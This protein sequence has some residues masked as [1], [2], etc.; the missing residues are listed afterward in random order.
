MRWRPAVTEATV[1]A[2]RDGR[3]PSP[4]I[5][6]EEIIWDF[7]SELLATRRVSD[8]TYDRAKAQFGE[9]GVVELCGLVGYYSLLAM[10][11]NVARVAPP[12]GETPLPR[13]PE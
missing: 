11:M 3:R 2:I 10:T 13:F 6:E 4:L 9:T 8:P 5:P 12:A 1:A 7:V